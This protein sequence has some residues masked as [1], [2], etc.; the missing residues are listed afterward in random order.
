M[1]F[2]S[3]LSKGANAT[4]AQCHRPRPVEMPTRPA[5]RGPDGRRWQNPNFTGLTQHPGQPFHTLGGILGQ[6]AGS[7]CKFWVSPVN[8][9]VRSAGCCSPRRRRSRGSAPSSTTTRPAAV[10]AGGPV[11]KYPSPLNVLKEPYDYSCC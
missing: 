1:M 3:D 5:A 11:I 8:F 10:A 9:T 4:A 2:T 7:T 6:T